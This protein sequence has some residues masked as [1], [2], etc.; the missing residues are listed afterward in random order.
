MDYFDPAT[1]QFGTSADILDRMAD[2]GLMSAS[3]DDTT[4]GVLVDRKGIQARTQLISDLLVKIAKWMQPLGSYPGGVL[5]SSLNSPDDVLATLTNWTVLNET[6]V[7]YSVAAMLEEGEVRM[8]F[9][10]EDAG[11]AIDKALDR[12]EKKKTQSFES[13]WALLAFDLNQD[14][15]L[16]F[17]ERQWS[18]KLS[19]VRVTF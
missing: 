10:Y 12:W 17:V 13:R 18:N 16:T 15:Q 19:S 1:S 8:R 2:V 3:Q 9:K 6:W 5:A 14:G 7:I 4:N 11:T